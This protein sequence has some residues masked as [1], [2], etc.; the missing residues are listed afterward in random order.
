MKSYSYKIAKYKCPGCDFIGDCELTMDIHVWGFHSDDFE[1]GVCD[2]TESGKPRN[3]FGVKLSL[4][5]PNPST[6]KIYI[7]NELWK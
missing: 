4:F 1:W 6:G 5:L 7:N 2:V 3:T